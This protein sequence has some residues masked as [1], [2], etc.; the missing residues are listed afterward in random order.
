QVRDHSG[1]RSTRGSLKAID[2]KTQDFELPLEFRGDHVGV[3]LGLLAL[4]E[5]SALHVYA[6]FIRTAG[7]HYVVT[8]HDLQ[9]LDRVRGDG[10][11]AMSQ[12]RGRVGVVNRSSEIVF[13]FVVVAHAL[14]SGE[15]VAMNRDTAR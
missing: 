4:S 9:A 15:D 5:S 1:V 12:V 3:L 8:L 11:I 7:E 10:G 6:V 14:E 13:R 2:G